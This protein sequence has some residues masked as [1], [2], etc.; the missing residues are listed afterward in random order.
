MKDD[1]IEVFTIGFD[2][3]NKDM[4]KDEREA[5]EVGAQELL[6]EGQLRRSSTISRR[7]PA[8]NSTT[9]SGRSSANTER[10]ALTQ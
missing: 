4:E 2:L 7:R 6:D 10:L 5:G 8:R 3:D 1:G 9:P